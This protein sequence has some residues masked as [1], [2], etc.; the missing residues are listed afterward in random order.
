MKNSLQFTR[1]YMYK[2]SPL[3]S[4]PRVIPEYIW[5]IWYSVFSNRLSIKLYNNCILY[6]TLYAKRNLLTFPG[7]VEEYF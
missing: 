4:L 3:R 1:L 2:S 5:I 7:V 6:V